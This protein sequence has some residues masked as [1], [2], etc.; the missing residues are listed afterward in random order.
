M[1]TTPLLTGLCVK[2][3]SLRAVGQETRALYQRQGR[4]A[5]HVRQYFW[6]GG[7]SGAVHHDDNHN[8]DDDC[9][10]YPLASASLA[11][12]PNNLPQKCE[13]VYI[14]TGDKLEFVPNTFQWQ[15]ACSIL[16]CSEWALTQIGRTLLAKARTA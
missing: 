13:G 5:I 15:F 1:S 4:A 3:S 8:N 6:E 16:L 14:H 12:V 11:A 9:N 10:Q 2:I 7:E